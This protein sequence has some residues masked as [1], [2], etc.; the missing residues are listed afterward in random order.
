MEKSVGNKMD[1]IGLDY[2]KRSRIFWRPPFI[3][4]PKDNPIND[5]NW[6]IYP[7]GIYN[8]L[9]RLNRYGVPILIT[10]NGVADAEDKYRA[11]FIKEHL[12]Y[13][14]K[15]ISEGVD[16]RGYFHW[17]LL[18]NFEWAWGWEPKFGL[19]TVDRETFKRTPRPSA[20][21]YKEICKNNAI[22]IEV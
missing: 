12:R 22:K 19:Y 4:N 2:Y 6:E 18:D 5:M 14:H 15:A 13:L 10:E 1:Y 21:I 3:R 9:K 11:D 17:S 16:V 8:A 20:K 7:K